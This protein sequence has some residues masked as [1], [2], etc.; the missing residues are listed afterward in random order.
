V[1]RSPPDGLPKAASIPDE[2]WR[3]A[4]A[5]GK[6][7]LETGSDAG[8]LLQET[9]RWL[10][11]LLQSGA[12]SSRERVEAGNI[13]T[14]V[15]DPRFRAKA[16]SLPDEPLLGFVEVPDGPFVMGEGEQRHEVTLPTF[17]IGRYHVTVA[18]FRAFVEDSGEEA[19]SPD[20]LRGLDNHPVVWVSWYE[21]RKYCQWLTRKL[22]GLSK[23]D[24]T[25]REQLF[26]QGL[27]DGSTVVTLPSEAEWEKAA[28]G[29]NGSTYPWGDEIDPDKANYRDTGIGT[30]SPVGCFP[31][32]L[33][34][35]GVADMSGNTWNWM[36][37]LMGKDLKKLEF[38]YPYDPS[39]GRENLDAE[40]EVLRGMRGGAFT[41]EPE[42][43]R[44]T[45]RDGVPPSGRDDADGFR[46][47]V[48]PVTA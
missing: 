12:L 7:S 30:T 44:S 21:A 47:V 26:W 18:Q 28:R 31:A 40:P 16:W 37:S 38:G 6:A 14:K 48:S 19:G 42:R 33:S 41:V 23:D 9:Q 11:A 10:V 46:V 2:T 35:Y 8:A 45:F 13:L 39:D 1:K 34:P 29:Q 17:Y 5:A 24:I 32:G 15:G 36:R 4:I 43:A 22:I 3:E 20:T 27:C 25:G